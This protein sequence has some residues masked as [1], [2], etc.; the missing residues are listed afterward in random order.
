MT[1]YK[2]VITASLLLLIIACAQ[3]PD[4]TPEKEVITT[5]ID[6]MEIPKTTGLKPALRLTKD[7]EDATKNW[8]LYQ[9][10]QSRLDSLDGYSL[11]DLKKHV[12]SL[13]TKIDS[14]EEAEESSVDLTPDNLESPSIKA[15]L[16]TV[17]TNLKVLNNSIQKNKPNPEEITQNIVKL[18]NAF[19]NLNLQINEHFAMS[20]DDMLKQMEEEARDSTSIDSIKPQNKPLANIP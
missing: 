10:I 11:G 8:P 9:S 5:T 18:K 19:Q 7:A 17:E 3:K 4:T 1:S 13:I 12:N 16:L 20:I 15:R 14:Q 2:T 6:S